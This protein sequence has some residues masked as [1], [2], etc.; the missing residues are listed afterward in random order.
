MRVAVEILGGGPQ[1]GLADRLDD[2]LLLL[3]LAGAEAIDLER[4]GDDVEDR[5]LGVDRV[6]GVLEDDLRL[7]A[8]LVERLLREALHGQALVEDVAAGGLFEAQEGAPGGR[9]AATALADQG[10]DLALADLEGDAVDGAHE[11][12]LG[13]DQAAEEA[14]LDGEVHLERAD[15]EEHAVG[16]LGRGEVADGDLALLVGGAGS[17]AGGGLLCGSHRFQ[18]PRLAR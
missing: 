8:V 13:G 3:A 2:A 6:V 11:L 18:S 12:L 9:L 16:D 15:I 10:E 17:A 7:L 1:A 5:L 4:L 14:L